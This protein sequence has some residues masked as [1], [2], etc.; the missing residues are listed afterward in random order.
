MPRTQRRPGLRPAAAGKAEVV[1]VDDDEAI[2]VDE[3]T[4]AGRTGSYA[5]WGAPELL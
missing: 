2:E 4:S 1:N 5:G 3:G